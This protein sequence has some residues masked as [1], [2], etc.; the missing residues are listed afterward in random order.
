MA[1]ILDG[2][3]LN[4]A[5]RAKPRAE[6]RSASIQERT[7]GERIHATAA[8]AH[9][10]DRP[11]LHQATQLLARI[12]PQPFDARLIP[13]AHVAV[14]VL[15]HHHLQP[16]REGCRSAKQKR[17]VMQACG[18]RVTHNPAEIGKLLE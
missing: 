15:R 11:Q 12:H 2:P 18:I 8:S 6:S 13:L 7:A 14:D 4:P 10:C 16:L 9:A 5:H 1:R 17:A 3:G